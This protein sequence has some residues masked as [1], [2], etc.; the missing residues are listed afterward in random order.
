M[1]NILIIRNDISK[2]F[3]ELSDIMES[4]LKSIQTYDHLKIINKKGFMEQPNLNFLNN[5]NLVLM[6]DEIPELRKIC[7]ANN[8][9]VIPNSKFISLASD[10]WIQ[11]EIL[12]ANNIQTPLT[13]KVTKSYLKNIQKTYETLL[14]EFD[15]NEFVFKKTKSF[16]G[17]DVHLVKNIKTF[18]N[19]LEKYQNEVN[20]LIVQ[21]FIPE[22]FGFDYRVLLSNHKHIITIV[23]QQTN[24]DEFRSN[25]CQGGEI[26]YIEPSNELVTL[27][28][29]VSRIFSADI[30]GID[31]LESNGIFYICEINTI[32]GISY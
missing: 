15:S 30:C 12:K 14:K 17:F 32:P 1:K 7:D 5:I 25:V 27:C 20:D 23:R 16:G 28:E 9:Q 2:S 3:T 31:I 6:Y 8:I 26:L 19:L 13:F 24:K 22:A 21:K 4:T 10:K 29:N 11:Y 18:K